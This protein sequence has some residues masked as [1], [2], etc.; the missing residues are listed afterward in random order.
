MTSL[1]KRHL[2]LV[3]IILLSAGLI[4]AI[5]FFLLTKTSVEAPGYM[6][7]GAVYAAK[8]YAGSSSPMTSEEIIIKS[9]KYALKNSEFEMFSGKIKPTEKEFI[10][11]NSTSIKEP[12]PGD[13]I[14]L[15]EAIKAHFAVI[16]RLD[17]D[18]VYF[19]DTEKGNRTPDIRSYPFSSP[20]IEGYRRLMLYKK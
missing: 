14:V 2:L 13:I 7:E 20:Y 16:T 1:D 5:D 15:R 10:F 3:I 8:K 19:A 4:I 9:Y 18:K 17:K 12:R 11:K 6:R